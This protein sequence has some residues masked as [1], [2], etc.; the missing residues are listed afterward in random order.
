MNI[1]T[2]NKTTTNNSQQQISTTTFHTVDNVTNILNTLQNN[3][4]NNL[5]TTIQQS[6]VE[7]IGK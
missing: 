1:A 5:C 3:I 4:S 2:N 7:T 6:S